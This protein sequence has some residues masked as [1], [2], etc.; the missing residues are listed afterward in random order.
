MT[1]DTFRRDYRQMTAQGVKFTPE[2]IV[3]LNALSV[4]VRLS[5]NAARSVHLPRLA[6]LP[7]V[8][9]LHAPPVLREPTIAHSLWLDEMGRWV[10]YSDGIVFLFVHAYALSRRAEDLPDAD[11]PQRVI[12]TVFR[13][14]ARRLSKYTYDQLSAAVDYALFGADWTIG[15]KPPPAAG[16]GGGCGIDLGVGSATIGLLVD[17][18]M[19]RLPISLDEARTMTASELS[20]AIDR[21]LVLDGRFDADKE[22]VRA[23]GDY[24]RAREEIRARSKAEEKT[25]GKVNAERG[26]KEHGDA[27]RG[28]HDH[29]G[30]DGKPVEPRP[31]G[32]RVV[33]VAVHVDTDSH[34]GE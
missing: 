29:L 13:H 31:G 14:A 24:V 17:M 32:V 22:K 4:R 8:S 12:K 20:E 21:A 6:F 10:D 11:R 18:K 25:S 27:D 33:D 3:R 16:K 2:D 5:A 26:E 9:W 15:E 7:R 23:L 28:D 1:T 30:P 34:G 19:L